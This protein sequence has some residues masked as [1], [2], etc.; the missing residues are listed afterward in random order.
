MFIKMQEIWLYVTTLTVYMFWKIRSHFVTAV[1]FQSQFPLYSRWS[2]NSFWNVISSAK[3]PTLSLPTFWS[4]CVCPR[5]TPSPVS[6][7]VIWMMGEPQRVMLKRN[8]QIFQKSRTH[9]RIIISVWTRM[10]TWGKFQTQDPQFWSDLW[11]P[12]LPEELIQLDVRRLMGSFA[13]TGGRG[14]GDKSPAIIMLQISDAPAQNLV[15]QQ[16][17]LGVADP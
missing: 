1:H 2:Y 16:L 5:T 12:F 17:H 13:P 8:P 14:E 3:S 9:L 6:P 15:G 4:C 11:T 10:A 7:W